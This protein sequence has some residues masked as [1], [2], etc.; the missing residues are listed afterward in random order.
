MDCPYQSVLIPVRDVQ[1]L[2]GRRALNR[3]R[4]E[5]MRELQIFCAIGFQ[6]AFHRERSTPGDYQAFPIFRYRDLYVKRFDAIRR[7]TVFPSRFGLGKSAKRYRCQLAYRYD[8]MNEQDFEIRF[9]DRRIHG[10][11]LDFFQPRRVQRRRER[12]PVMKEI[13]SM[14]LERGGATGFRYRNVYVR[15][16]EFPSSSAFARLEARDVFYEEPRRI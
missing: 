6:G 1:F 5:F 7:R 13:R 16:F 2:T 15:R 4:P 10:V 8:P 9:H 12:Q 11:H 3:F 14:E